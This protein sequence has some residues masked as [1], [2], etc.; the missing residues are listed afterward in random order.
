MKLKIFTLNLV[1]YLHTATVAPLWKYA[2]ISTGG[3]AI[4]VQHASYCR[5][6]LTTSAAIRSY[7]LKYIA[8]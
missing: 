1:E 8:I 3:C 4:T 6:L 5:L 2:I 7:L